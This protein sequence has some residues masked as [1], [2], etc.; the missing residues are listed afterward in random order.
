MSLFRKKPAEPVAEAPAEPGVRLSPI[1]TLILADAAVR[2]GQ[3]LVRRGV[4]QGLL[5]GDS[6]QTG[7]VLRGRTIRETVIGTVLAEVARRSVPGAILV[8]GGLIAEALRNRRLEKIA[9]VEAAK[10]EAKAPAQD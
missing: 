5:K 9:K 10:A 4:E 8:G 3:A 7:R 1:A 6:A 2:A